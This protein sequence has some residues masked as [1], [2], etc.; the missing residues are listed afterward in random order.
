[1]KS[2]KSKVN[3]R[4]KQLLYCSLF[5]VVFFSWYFVLGYSADWIIVGIVSGL[6]NGTIIFLLNYSIPVDQ[7]WTPLEA[8]REKIDNYFGG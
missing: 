5:G 3:N 2:E 1:M 4:L 7:F 8:K 6:I